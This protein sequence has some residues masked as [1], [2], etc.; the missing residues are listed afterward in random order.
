[1]TTSRSAHASGTT[2][3]RWVGVLAALVVSGAAHF[4]TGDRR[5]GALWFCGLKAAHVAVIAV[6]LLTGTTDRPLTKPTDSYR[7]RVD[8]YYMLGDCSEKSYDSRFYG[9]VRRKDIIGRV[10]RVYW[11]PGRAE[12]A[13][14]R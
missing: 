13:V 1:M 11:P 4:L 14:G 3:P 2:Y 7:L 5:T 12:Q 6:L 10:V 8:E 9:G